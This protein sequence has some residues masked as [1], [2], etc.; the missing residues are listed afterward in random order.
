MN[1]LRDWWRQMFTPP[2]IPPVLRRDPELPDERIRAIAALAK[3][4]R[5]LARRERL[6]IALQDAVV[7]IRARR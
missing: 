2:E 6:D 4:E 1:R 3:A 7:R 5:A